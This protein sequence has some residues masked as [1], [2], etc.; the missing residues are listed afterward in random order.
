MVMYQE[1]GIRYRTF[2]PEVCT[3]NGIEWS[4]NSQE[5]ER[6]EA[7]C[8]AATAA[9][10][11]IPGS[12]PDFALLQR[13]WRTGEPQSAATVAA[14]FSIVRHGGWSFVDERINIRRSGH[15]HS[16]GEFT[17][18]R[19]TRLIAPTAGAPG[20]QGRG[21]ALPSSPA[22]LGRAIDTSEHEVEPANPELFCSEVTAEIVTELRNGAA[23][24]FAAGDRL[25]KG[26]ASPDH[27]QRHEC[28]EGLCGMTEGLIEP[29]AHVQTKAACERRARHRG[30]LPDAFDAEPA[31]GIDSLDRE[32]KRADRQ[33]CDC[34]YGGGA[35]SAALRSRTGTRQTYRPTTAMAA[36]AKPRCPL[37]DRDGRKSA[38]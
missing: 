10:E 26:E 9:E 1:L 24:G 32:A 19:S 5:I 3:S 28:V 6:I 30:E 14:L 31:E 11:R 37:C 12:A 18:A 17:P 34:G 7:R 23:E 35:G 33:F 21:S 29:A 16:R 4:G 8:S 38:L 2:K 13:S 20:E 36:S 27:L 25:G 22:P 15:S